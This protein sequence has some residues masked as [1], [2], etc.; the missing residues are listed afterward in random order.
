MAKRIL[1]P[2]GPRGD[3]DTLTALVA[4]V[5]RG[6]GATVRLLHVMPPPVTRTE[7][8]GR[9]ISYASQEIDSLEAR[10]LAYLESLGAGLDGVPVEPRV[11]FGDVAAEILLEAD[12]FGAEL[13]ALRARPRRWW[14]PFGLGGVARRVARKTAAPVMV[15]AC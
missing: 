5:A 2:I 7:K 11:R 1:V 15:L 6:A 10:G 9:V 8:S 13:I 4:D 3:L 12:G 14:R